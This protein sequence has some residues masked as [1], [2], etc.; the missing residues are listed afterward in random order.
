MGKP[1]A[2]QAPCRDASGV[3]DSAAASDPQPTGSARP[4]QT[5][6]RGQPRR[7]TAPSPRDMTGQRPPRLRATQ[8]SATIGRPARSTT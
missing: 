5:R 1:K 7:R 2:N 4:Q 6:R 8:L 3:N